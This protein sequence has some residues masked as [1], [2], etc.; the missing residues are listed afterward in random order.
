MS[1]KIYLGVTDSRWFNYLAAQQPDEVNFWMPGAS[2]FKALPEAGLFLFKLKSPNDFVVGVG[3]FVRYTR[4]PVMLAWDA[5]GQKIRKRERLLPLSG[6]STGS[7][8][9]GSRGAAG[10]GLSAVAQ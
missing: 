4:L 1:T 7:P 9:Q 5:F 8:A 2:G 3:F 6:P 10:S